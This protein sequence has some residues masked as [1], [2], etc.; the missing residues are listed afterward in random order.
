MV[1]H[2]HF[3]NKKINFKPVLVT[4]VLTLCVTG[5][6]AQQDTDA[7]YKIGDMVEPFT[8]PNA[9]GQMIN[10]FDNDSKGYIIVFTNQECKYVDLYEGRIQALDSNY[11][12]LGYPVIAI[13]AEIESFEMSTSGLP[14]YIKKN[15][16]TYDYLVDMNNSIS[17]SFQVQSS[18]QALILVRTTDGLRLVYSGSID[19]NGRRPASVTRKYIEEA[20]ED[21]MANRTLRQP[22]TKSIGCHITY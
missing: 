11:R 3:L 12:A 20:M 15:D 10:V 18:P 14:D 9:Y 22:Q 6:F 19:N 5:S 1:K 21:I 13:E 7:S 8:L 16:I 17:K 2:T 4:M